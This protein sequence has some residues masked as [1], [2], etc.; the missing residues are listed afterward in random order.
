MLIVVKDSH[1][2][3]LE[4]RSY[5]Y[6]HCRRGEGH[7]KHSYRWSLKMQQDIPHQRERSL[8]SSG[9]ESSWLTILLF[10]SCQLKEIIRKFSPINSY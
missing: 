9:L 7:L 6:G 1:Y 4:V 2:F 3:N 10:K 5:E 8:Y